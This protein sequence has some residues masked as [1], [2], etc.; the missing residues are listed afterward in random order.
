MLAVVLLIAGILFQ[1]YVI[2]DE[3]E[4]SLEAAFMV[5]LPDEEKNEY[6]RELGRIE[7]E[8]YNIESELYIKGNNIRV[9]KKEVDKITKRY[10][11][12]EKANP[13][14]DA[15]ERLL[16]KEALYLAAVKH[17]YGADDSEVRERIR[18]VKDWMCESENCDYYESFFACAELTM[19]EYWEMRYD[20][21]MKEVVTEKYLAPLQE[22]FLSATGLGEKEAERL[23]QAEQRKIIQETI[24]EDNIKTFD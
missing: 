1:S 22:T 13:R 10:T 7:K 2:D 11:L 24:K 16:S 20:D 18:S 3:E 4:R 23:W 5:V 19:D 14:N 9:Y 12:M 21:V 6:F 17:G 15:I 8:F